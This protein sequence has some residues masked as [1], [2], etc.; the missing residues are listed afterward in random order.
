MEHTV[1]FR[2][3]HAAGSEAETDFLAAAAELAVIPGVKNFQ[4]RRQISP[5]NNLAFGIAMRFDTDDEFQ[6]YS[7]HPLHTSFVQERWLP[8]VEEFLEADFEVL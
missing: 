8:G 5:K 1:M 6:V 3:K 2:L 7:S 4:I